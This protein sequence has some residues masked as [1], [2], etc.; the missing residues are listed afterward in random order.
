MLL[1]AFLAIAGMGHLT[2]ARQEFQA[3]VPDW[4]PLD[5]DLTVVLSGIV[6]VV[7]GSLLI[8][9]PTKYRALAGRIVA[10]FFLA[11]FPG[12][13]SQYLTQQDAFGLNSNI[14]RLI[15]LFFQPVLIVW[16]LWSTK[17][18]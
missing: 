13:I 4:V 5:K 15:R 10:L 11:V 7:L 1:G 9:A 14:A 12:N 8:F 3:Q 18:K 16:A 6:E 17:G 2:F